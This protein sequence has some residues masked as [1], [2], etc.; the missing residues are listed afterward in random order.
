MNFIC[1]LSPVEI[2]TEMYHPLSWSL[3]AFPFA[4]YP[5]Y[6]A[7]NSRPLNS[8]QALVCESGLTKTRLTLFSLRRSPWTP[9]TIILL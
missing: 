7:W 5:I 1:N 9:P 6:F 3:L 2:K 8:L 4:I